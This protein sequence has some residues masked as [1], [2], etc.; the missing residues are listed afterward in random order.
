[1]N[2]AAAMEHYLAPAA[3]SDIAGLIPKEADSFG[4]GLWNVIRYAMDAL[5]PSLSEAAEYCLQI[6]TVVLLCSIVSVFFSEKRSRVTGFI[7]VSSVSMTLLAP[8]ASFIA[9]GADT[10]RSLSEYSRLLLPVMTGALATQGGTSTAAALYAT[11]A[12]LDTV[13]SSALTHVMLPSLRLYLC[14]SIANA[15]IGEPLLGKVRD[16]IKWIMTWMLKLALYIFTGF[17]SITGVVTGAAD[18]ASIKAAKIAISGSVPVVGSILSDASDAV[19]S[20]AALM[21][22]SA[23][24][25]GLLTFLGICAAPFIRIGAQHLLLKATGALCMSFESGSSSKLILDFSAAMGLILG[26]VATQ[27]VLLLISTICF[28]KGVT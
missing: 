20:G 11:T 17:L 4:Q 5:T 8:S 14:L 25:Y 22:S 23:G 9:L 15:A 1:M 7:A 27:T 13:L 28:M 10:A 19:L 2:L 3:P 24:V 21:K 26:M 16:F 18:A 6:C 12:F